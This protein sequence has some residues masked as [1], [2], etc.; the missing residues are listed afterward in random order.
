MRGEFD[1]SRAVE[2]LLGPSPTSIRRAFIAFGGILS[3]LYELEER[4]LVE[5]ATATTWRALR[6]LPDHGR[7]GFG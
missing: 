1:P 6:S 4:E 7:L 5:R 3:Q 2:D